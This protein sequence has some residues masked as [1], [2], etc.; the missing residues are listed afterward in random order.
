MEDKTLVKVGLILLVLAVL[1]M[2]SCA[3][4]KHFRK[5]KFAEYYPER[6][7]YK[8]DKKEE[9]ARDMRGIVPFS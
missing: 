2:S 5:G 6:T 9:L 7:E 8:L 3:T 4:P 1:I